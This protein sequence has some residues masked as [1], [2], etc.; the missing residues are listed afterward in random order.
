MIDYRYSPRFLEVTPTFVDFFYNEVVNEGWSFLY[1]ARHI[2]GGRTAIVR[3]FKDYPR[4]KEVYDIYMERKRKK[5]H[6][7]YKKTPPVY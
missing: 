1:A 5:G 4:L 2:K 6:L 7:H 3:R